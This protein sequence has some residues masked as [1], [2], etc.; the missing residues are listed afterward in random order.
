MINTEDIL[1][2]DPYFV[3]IYFICEAIFKENTGPHLIEYTV[4]DPAVELE[5]TLSDLRPCMRSQTYFEIL[6]LDPS[7]P[8]TTTT[9]D[10]VLT[11][12]V[13]TDDLSWSSFSIE[14]ELREIDPFDDSK[15]Q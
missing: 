2:L 15:F 11:L 3:P 7:G 10:Q 9:A 4:Q 14:V 8:V 12:I 1:Q 5:F 13:Q 6:D